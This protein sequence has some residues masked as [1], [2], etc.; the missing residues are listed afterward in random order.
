MASAVR[1]LSADTAARSRLAAPLGA[2]AAGFGLVSLAPAQAQT[3]PAAPVPAASAPAEA[4]AEAAARQQQA[5]PT[6]TVK[7]QAER[8]GKESVQALTT[9]IGK[10]KQELRDVPQSV[11]V[12]TERL[13]DDRNL[14]TL[15]QALTN[16]AG[17]SFLAAEGGEE[18]I[19]VRGFSL[20]AAGDIYVDGMRDPAMYD[21]DT[22]NNDR[23]D[24][25]RGSASMLF[26]RG[27]TGGVVNQVSKQPLLI[28]QHEVTAT[29]GSQGYLRG[30]GDFNLRTGD[31]A[32][33]RLNVMN[34]LA[35]NGGARID[36]QG[37]A[38]T[39]RW[40]IGT[41]DEFSLGVYHLQYDNRPNYG[42][43]WLNGR[44]PE[45]DAGN[46][47]G[48]ASDYWRGK[49][50]FTT[51]AH[52]HRFQGGGELKTQLRVGSFERDFWA[53][54]VRFAA[55]TTA[56]NLSDATVLN[57]GNQGRQHTYDTR[58][59]QT[60]YS[61]SFKALGM[62]HE[63]LAGADLASESISRY[64]YSGNP[65]KPPTTVGTPNDGASLADT[66]TK[67][68]ATTFDATA[69]GAYA[70]D[71][72][73]VSRDW[74]VVAGLRVDHFKGDYDRLPTA[75]D[76]NTN[77][78]RSD[79]NWSRRF[80]V[81]YQPSPEASYHFS[82]GTSFNTSGDTYQYD[83]GTAKTPPESS[84]NLELGAKLDWLEGRLSTR[85]AAFYSEKYNERNRDTDTA[86]VQYLL[87]GKRHAAGLEFDVA[88]RIGADW[89]VFASYAWIPVA[90]VDESTATA[91]EV[92]G[93]RPGLTPRQTGS[94]WTT[95]RV[96]PKL[97][98]GAG[99]TASGQQ[100]PVGS[101]AV[102]PGYVIGDV[103]AEYD[104]GEV[105]F[106]LNV[107]NVGDK[108]YGASLYRGHVVLGA[109]RTTQLT[110]GA[111]F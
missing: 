18:D 91:G 9:T 16:T 97:R 45:V 75:T 31:D 105:F 20:A 49:A 41:A 108:L 96:T 33:L 59:V 10:G 35:E 79:T 94:L 29:V 71:M 8:Q 102:A 52:T 60:D 82:Y 90:K 7:G 5:L 63:L 78:G 15:K 44:P 14:D 86:V 100:S 6:V 17:I 34:T 51:L 69:V 84:R 66:R 111:R 24:V 37:I 76:P 3:A 47:Y 64:N 53:S 109:P 85:V 48:L 81:L 12:V 103:M 104:L 43:G 56:A 25:L 42:I 80:G 67:T 99:L 101:T 98:L 38:P 95:W 54:T 2:L 106:K 89:E 26:G 110:I 50:T 88:G 13:I 30:T 55:G 57:R 62:K 65:A 22:F 61:G 58:Y 36:K 28:N 19:R 11:T 73:Q 70:Q 23:I 40:G 83:S 46:Y 32:A 93:S 21:R 1:P 72:V 74:K 27:S 87:S 92:E 77:Y 107:T 4:A 68:W 39:F